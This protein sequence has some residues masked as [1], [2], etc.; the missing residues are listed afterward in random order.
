MLYNTMPSMDPNLV[1]MIDHVFLPPKLPQEE[2]SNFGTCDFLTKT[3]HDAIKTFPDY[4]PDA[5][6]PLWDTAAKMMG[7]LLDGTIVGID[8][9]KLDDRLAGMAAGGAYSPWRMDST[10]QSLHLGQFD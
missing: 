4:L 6:K 9:G 7:A 5:E 1:Y 2:D 8:A 3:V 10:S